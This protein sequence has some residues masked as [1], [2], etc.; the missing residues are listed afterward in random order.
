MAGELS[1]RAGWE[2]TLT[3]LPGVVVG[4]VLAEGR[5]LWQRSRK[6]SAYWRALRTEIE[7]A[8]GRAPMVLDDN[9]TSPLYRLP[10]LIFTTCFSDLLSE[11][12]ASETES[13]ALMAFYAEVD[14]LNRG[15]DRAADSDEGVAQAEYR[16]NRVKAER[17]VET[18]TVYSAAAL[19]RRK[20][21]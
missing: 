4:F 20:H 17:L 18:G 9:F 6:Q 16:R 19:A 10:T 1:A 11:R 14:T 5:G 7:I 3:T 21:V 2:R 13:H 8:R 15:L 12:S